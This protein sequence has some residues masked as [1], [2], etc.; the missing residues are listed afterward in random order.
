[1]PAYRIG[2]YPVTV[3]EYAAFIKD[4]KDQ[5]VPKDA[6]WFLREPPAGK[7]D[8]PVTG[9]SW[10]DAMAYCVWLSNR[11]GR[12]YRLPTEAEWEKAARGPDGHLYP[13]GDKWQE[14]PCNVEGRDTTPVTSHPAGA[15]AY[16]CQDMLGNVQEWTR[17]QWGS[18]PQQPDFGYPYNPLD[19]REI[20]DPQELP[21]QARLV[22]R[23]G[24]FKST[25]AETRTTL[26][27]HAAPDSRVP[28]RGFRVA[29]S[30]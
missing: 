30:V 25:P 11:T 28:W 23:G 21:P 29:M 7:L 12:G 20:G 22:Q 5:D 2:K 18:R 6:G 13:W 9:V 14:G 26:R 27:G 3:R 8:H 19:G 4:K 15:S 17:S 1:M 24:S 10:H 16:Y